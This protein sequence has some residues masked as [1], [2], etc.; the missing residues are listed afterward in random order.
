MK[1]RIQYLSLFIFLCLGHGLMAQCYTI[2]CSSCATDP[3]GDLIGN[4]N[5]G[6]P[7]SMCGDQVEIDIEFST[8][9]ALSGASSVEVYYSIDGTAQTSLTGVP[10]TSG[11]ASITVD[12][13]FGNTNEICVDSVRELTTVCMEN[14]CF[15]VEFN[16]NPAVTASATPSTVCEGDM[17]TFNEEE[18]QTSIWSWTGPDNF[19]SPMRSPEITMAA[20]SNGG[21]YMLTA[22]DANGCSNTDEV[23]LTVKPN[24]DVNI[25]IQESS[26]SI[27]ND[28]AICQGD[29]VTLSVPLVNGATYMWD[30]N[31]NT[32]SNTM[33]DSPFPSRDYTVQVNLDGCILENT[34]QINVTSTPNIDPGTYNPVCDTDADVNLSATPTG[35][36]WSGTGVT[37]GGG[38]N[39]SFDPSG[40][41]GDIEISY[42]ID[43]NGCI[44][45]TTIMINVTR[46][47][48]LSNVQG[49]DA[50]SCTMNDGQIT[51]DCNLSDGTYDVLGI[52]GVNSV[53]VS[54]GSAT[55]SD[56]AAATY[57]F[58]IR[59]GDCTSTDQTVTIG[60]PNA[61]NVSIP[62]SNENEYC[63]NDP[64]NQLVGNPSGGTWSGPG[65]DMNSGL[66]TPS[67]AGVG[68]HTII[69][70]F[71]DGN[72]C[73]GSDE[74]DLEVFDIPTVTLSSP[75]NEVCINDNPFNLN[76]SPSG[77]I[78]S[79]TGISNGTFTPSQAG[80][81]SHIITYTV[82]N[83][84]NCTNSASVTIEVKDA[85]TVSVSG[86]N[87]DMCEN[88]NSRQLTGS[89]SGGA[90]SGPGV[91]NN[92]LFDPSG[93][94][95]STATLTYTFTNGQGC[96][97]EA[98]ISIVV[99]PSP[100]VNIQ[101]APGSLCEN[102][103][104]YMLMASPS[105]GQWFGQG[106]SS[107][108]I[109]DP[110]SVSPGNITVFYRLTNAQ[111]CSDQETITIE[112]LAAPTASL[113]APGALCSNDSPVQLTGTPANG[114]FS[115]EGVNNNGL[116][117]PALVNGPSSDITYT[118]TSANG[119]FDTDT[120]TI[121]INAAP[122]VS[123]AAFDNE[124]CLDESPFS[125]PG[126]PAG[127]IYTSSNP[128]VSSNG[129]FTPSTAGEGV[130]SF[131][132]TF[133]NNE[134]CTDME[135]GSIR[136]FPLP[137][138]DIDI[139]DNSGINND[140]T[141][142]RGD[143][144]RLEAQPSG[145][146]YL[147]EGGQITN[148]TSQIEDVSPSIRTTYR[149]TVTDSNGCT[150]FS[151]E[152]IDVHELPRSDFEIATPFNPIFF[153]QP[154][155]LNNNSVISPD[156]T[157]NSYTWC[158]D[159]SDVI[160]LNGQSVNAVSLFD[161]EANNNNGTSSESIE[162][163]L[164]VVD[165]NQC[166]DEF[167]SSVNVVA[168][169]CFAQ[170]NF[171]PTDIFC[172]GE[173]IDINFD[174]TV[175]TGA[176]LTDINARMRLGSN[177][178][179]LSP[180]PNTTN[181]RID[182]PRIINNPGEWSFQL[183]FSDNNT[184]LC[185]NVVQEYTVRIEE[186][187]NATFENLDTL[188]ACKG[189]GPIL[190][191][192]NINFDDLLF[193]DNVE[194]S[195]DIVQNGMLLRQI[196]QSFNPQTSILSLDDSDLGAVVAGEFE[197]ILRN[198]ENEDIDC[199][200]VA[201]DSRKT[202]RIF[203][204]LNYMVSNVQ[205]EADSTFSFNITFIGG[206]GNYEIENRIGVLQS[207]LIDT[208][209]GTYQYLCR[210]D[211]YQII[212]KDEVSNC[213]AL[214][215]NPMELEPPG[216][217]CDF[218]YQDV[219]AGEISVN[220]GV[221]IDNVHRLCSDE[222]FEITINDAQFTLATDSLVLFVL[223]EG[224]IEDSILVRSIRDIP[225]S[226]VNGNTFSASIGNLNNGVEY[227]VYA[228]VVQK[229]RDN[230]SGLQSKDLTCKRFSPNIRI[231]FYQDPNPMPIIDD[232]EFCSNESNIILDAS[233]LIPDSEP[234]F[235]SSSIT[236]EVLDGNND[237]SISR[238]INGS[239][240]NVSLHLANSTP[241]SSYNLVLTEEVNYRGLS[242]ASS[243]VTP[244]TTTG[245][246]APDT[247][248]IVYWPGNI[249]ACTADTANVSFRWG[250]I[251]HA[252]GDTDNNNIGSGKFLYL[253]PGLDLLND[254]DR[255]YYVVLRD[256]NDTENRCSTIIYFSPTE[257]LERDQVEGSNIVQ[258]FP[259]PSDG[260]LTFRAIGINNGRY[261][262]NVFNLKGE[263]VQ[264]FIE[265]KE[266]YTQ[267]TPIYLNVP[268]GLYLIQSIGPDQKS[269]IRKIIIQ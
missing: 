5:N 134:G 250:F 96:S 17:V 161:I 269:E 185:N 257:A 60:Q 181:F 224:S 198:I 23:T 127:G 124:V 104:P 98:S 52:S 109:F 1:T 254:V 80:V 43:E 82:Q 209:A 242:C 119:C 205:C 239:E 121:I 103:M 160:N 259:N 140:Q 262:F 56:L 200:S 94:G 157:S 133:T 266:A 114:S 194:I 231:L 123:I 72:G 217:D 92:G 10:V 99:N 38:G 25:S 66:F 67:D 73:T 78:W 237:I 202:I 47:P 61:P 190:L 101:N 251:D 62:G 59:N 163:T 171:E 70:T 102:D 40:L 222:S 172:K 65:I 144:I 213:N 147:W 180:T 16:D 148:S 125:I 53:M 33:T 51:F 85:P 226:I 191:P 204:R 248:S 197:I 118:F 170:T 253:D 166:E 142:C 20:L 27:D 208:L 153:D 211:N 137:D 15:H 4:G 120:R 216:C 199:P 167:Q 95:G 11:I 138:A 158:F 151:N 55:I 77:G 225:T 252:N 105:G 108:G 30:D 159:P 227:T 75:F 234:G 174:I 154:F 113:T 19:S 84:N 54:G 195:Y 141:I 179:V 220:N 241:N 206:T 268:P 63:L 18:G 139:T 74:F 228:G 32:T 214:D 115:G 41:Q 71:T 212:L 189:S 69:Y 265:V 3:S 22:T 6:N 243:F 110:S 64:P 21:L 143:N 49:V 215:I 13:T 24:P 229:S 31:N 175:S 173:I 193:T 81:G 244:I 86:S 187:P 240:S 79:G 152:S 246:V 87:A 14:A 48:V 184:Q 57:T 233:N 116:F 100:D 37:D 264:H 90:W 93:L 232:T 50:T 235:E 2:S 176:I 192:L 223:N 230:A 46:T 35:G 188:N 183:M 42:T 267:E 88:D 135:N 136:V 150:D 130:A 126:N 91:D 44:T 36:T 255:T 12:G 247:A 34:Q 68:M 83:S 169:D 7:Y 249:L 132:Y 112:V 201:L 28:G 106:V 155:S 263:R 168:M 165:D 162:I 129:L 122:N 218:V 182:D 131:T 107:D 203:D 76:G 196:S 89:P 156:A 9:G 260:R 29:P 219:V 178:I 238:S 221:L 26:G 117:D 45:D 177:N 210:L 236:W 207:T 111:G 186:D 149:V 245:D 39:G 145:I 261:H 256:R 146:S 8:S 58:R 164:K 128:G 258:L 97:D